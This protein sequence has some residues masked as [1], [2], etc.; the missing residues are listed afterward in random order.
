MTTVRLKESCWAF[1]EKVAGWRVFVVLGWY[2]YFCLRFSFPDK[3][4]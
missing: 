2:L 3:A 4:A 1:G